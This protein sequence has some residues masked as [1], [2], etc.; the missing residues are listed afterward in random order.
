KAVSEISNVH[1]AQILS[2]LKATNLNVGLIINFAKT[3]I[4]IIRVVND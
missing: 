4:D 3:K 2:Y 1:R